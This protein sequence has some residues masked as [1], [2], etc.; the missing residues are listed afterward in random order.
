M[1]DELNVF[2]LVYPFD[3]IASVI[4]LLLTIMFMILMTV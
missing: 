1:D 4:I 3:L 2:G